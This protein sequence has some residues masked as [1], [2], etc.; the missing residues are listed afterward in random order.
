MKRVRFEEPVAP[1]TTPGGIKKKLKLEKPQST[2]LWRSTAFFHFPPDYDPPLYDFE[3]DPHWSPDETV[4]WLGT[5]GSGKTTGCAF[6]LLKRRYAYANAFCMTNTASNNYWQQILPQDKVVE[7]FDEELCQEL[8]DLCMENLAKFRRLYYETNKAHGVPYNVAIFE[9]LIDSN[10]LRTSR[11]AR[12]LLYNGRHAGLAGHILSQDYAG[13]S[14]AQRDNIDRIVIFKTTDL[15]TRETF[16]RQYG[17]EFL[18]MLDRV[19][20][21]PNTVLLINNRARVPKEHMI[22]KMVVDKDYVD[23]AFKSGKCL[24]NKMCWGDIDLD[25]QRAALPYIDF[26]PSIGMMR[27]KINDTVDES[28]EE[29]KDAI[30]KTPL[31]ALS[32]TGEGEQGD[33][34]E[35]D[36]RNAWKTPAWVDE[37][38]RAF[39]TWFG[40][41]W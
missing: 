4:Y 27:R 7:G 8:I 15:A 20:A 33:S 36:E 28:E 9:D 25:E 19:T 30:E 34:L 10:L 16:A 29:D 35:E 5:R 2:A 39:S 17:V 18:A 31:A 13:L 6:Y 12:R 11:A 26:K 14:R 24:G 1:Q 40:D 32:W 37:R 23:K 21:Q 3:N 22:T 41:W 38:L